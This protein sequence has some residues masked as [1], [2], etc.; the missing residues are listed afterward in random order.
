MIVG[1]RPSVVIMLGKK[2]FS[3]DKNSKG[4]STMKPITLSSNNKKK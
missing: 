4:K 3:F 2:L 1:A